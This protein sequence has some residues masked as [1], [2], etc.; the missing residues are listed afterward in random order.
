MNLLCCSRAHPPPASPHP[1]LCIED[2]RKQTVSSKS[3]AVLA[4]GEKSRDCRA[5]WPGV[6]NMGWEVPLF[7]SERGLAQGS[8]LEAENRPCPCPSPSGQAA[9]GPTSG[10]QCAHQWK[11]L[12]PRTRAQSQC[13]VPDS[14]QLQPP[15]AATS[16]RAPGQHFL[17]PECQV[18]GYLLLRVR[19]P[20]VGQP[21]TSQPERDRPPERL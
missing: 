9:R 15:A 8:V 10:H 7:I 11:S 20:E 17:L 1:T 21:R 3:Q 16:L 4:V 2:R 19:H 6:D 14:H 12:K 13:R 18:R 5:W